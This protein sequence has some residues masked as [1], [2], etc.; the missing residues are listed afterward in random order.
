MTEFSTLMEKGKEATN[1]YLPEVAVIQ[2]IIDETSDI[3]TFRLVIK[4]REKLKK[5]SFTSGQVGQVSLF[6]VGESTFAISSSPKTKDFLEF[7]VMRAGENS[8]ALHELSVG[9]AVGVRA[10]FG[11]GFPVK[12]MEG[13]NILVIGGGIGIA[14]LRS[15]I[16]YLL[17]ERE[18]YK[19]VKIIYGARTPNDLCFRRDLRAWKRRDDIECILAVDNKFPGW[20]GKVGFVPAILAEEAPAPANTVAVTCGPPIM[21][22]FVLD[23]LKKLGFKKEHIVTT[24]ER[25][26]K[27]GVGLCGRCNVG[28]KYVC[29]DGP[30]FTLAQLEELPNEI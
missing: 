3:K 9:D 18:K 16:F 1:P 29:V 12:E 24:L 19:N 30:V 6:G 23:E 10:P 4:N 28:P 21:I 13:K 2:K 20:E 15:L 22:K 14:P 25:R 5:F 27:C 26:M 8:S 17:G 11:N 7:S